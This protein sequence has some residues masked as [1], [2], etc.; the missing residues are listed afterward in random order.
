MGLSCGT[1]RAGRDLG[2]P[3]VFP[4]VFLLWAA[5]SGVSHLVILESCLLCLEQKLKEGAELVVFV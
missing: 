2:L 5:G 4:G 3:G 1:G